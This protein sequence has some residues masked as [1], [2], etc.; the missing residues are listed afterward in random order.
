MSKKFIGVLEVQLS[1]LGKSDQFPE[2]IST[3]VSRL[4]CDYLRTENTLMAADERV[5]KLIYKMELLNAEKKLLQREFSRMPKS[6]VI[7]F[8]VQYVSIYEYIINV[9]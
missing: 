3:V 1:D 6:E 5:E 7:L 4:R 8:I 9:S 2:N